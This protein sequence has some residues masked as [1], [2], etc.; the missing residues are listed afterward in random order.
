MN[1]QK[2]SLFGSPIAVIIVILFAILM[3]WWILLNPFNPIPET[4][5][6]R[7]IWG[8]I[9]QIMAYIGGISGIFIARKWGGIKSFLGKSIFALSIGLL[10][11]G[12]GQ[13]V[14][15]YYLF[16]Q[17]IAAPYPSLGDLGYFGTI[18]FY[19]YG[20]ILLSHI[21]GIKLSLKSYRNKL[22]A[23]I[24]PVAMLSICYFLFLQNYSFDF[25]TPLKTFLDFGYPLGQAIYVSIAILVF[26]FSKNVLSGIMRVP[27]LFLI[28]AL[29]LQ[30]FSDY[31]FLFQF[32]AG[33]WYVGGI[34]DFMYLL[35]YFLMAISL[36]QLGTVFDHIKNS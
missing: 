14:Y 6:V 36:I 34:N 35:S 28:T 9:Y 33:N 32:N 17:H 23:L 8:G 1:L 2:H 15:T 5:S 24:I 22:L 29:I 10:C 4:E 13:S 26:M 30:F 3:S 19:I 25:S 21:S 27:I 11:Q 12:F 7:N 18:P 20:V 31:I 16:S